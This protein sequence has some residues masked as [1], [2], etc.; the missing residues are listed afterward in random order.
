MKNLVRLSILT[1][2]AGFFA[3]CSDE[4]DCKNCKV[5]YYENNVLIKEDNAI[6]YCGDELKDVENQPP[7][8]VVNTT[9]K[10]VCE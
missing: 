3:S 5:V 1:F 7:V 4:S 8:T 2:L 6:K 10:Y 9:T